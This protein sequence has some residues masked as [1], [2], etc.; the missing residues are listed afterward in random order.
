MNRLIA[1]GLLALAAAGCQG[2]PYVV[3]FDGLWTGTATSADGAAL[4]MVANFTWNEEAVYLNGTVDIDGWEYL[5][6]SV[7]SDKDS[8]DMVLLHNTGARKC[9]ITETVVDDETLSGAFNIDTCYNAGAAPCPLTGN[10]NLMRQG[11]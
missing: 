7:S 4:I 9:D 3:D 1:V 10:F 5:I 8:A 6:N 2:K 11:L